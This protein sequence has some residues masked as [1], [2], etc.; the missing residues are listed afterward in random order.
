MVLLPP[1]KPTIEAAL[2]DVDS[3]G[4]DFRLA[5]A[6]AL[7]DAPPAHRKAALEGLLKLARDKEPLV[8]RAAL[9]ALGSFAGQASIEQLLH[10]AEHAIGDHDPRVVDAAFELMAAIGEPAIERLS[11]I[12]SV[13]ET[14]RRFL[15]ARAL[16]EAAS[17]EAREQFL[18]L[19]PDRD[20]EFSAALALA[21]GDLREK[22]AIPKLIDALSSGHRELQESAALAL[23]DL[24]RDEGA[25]VLIEKLK[26]G[27]S[28]EETTL[29]L[30]KIRAAEAAPALWSVASKRLS[31][32]LRQS[33]ALG[34]L[35][36][37][38]D[39]RAMKALERGLRAFFPSRRAITAHA[40]AEFRIVA[41]RPAVEAAA[42]GKLPRALAL[43]ILETLDEP[44]AVDE[45]SR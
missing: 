18:S 21:L 28:I 3:T 30:G 32:A 38:G 9:R 8:R 4:K 17:T 19:F 31:P 34:A 16:V 45:R 43:S 5:A 39:E 7:A 44:E 25:R 36:A 6:D 35:A 12:L 40:I 2:R 1:L 27:D 29:A 24:G 41:L 10:E 15:A 42:K 37:L 22:R 26:R 11:A 20:P 33:L 23:A 13:G 14:S